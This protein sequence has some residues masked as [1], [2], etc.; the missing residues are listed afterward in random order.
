MNCGSSRLPTAA[1]PATA[2]AAAETLL[3]VL[4]IYCS[5]CACTSAPNVRASIVENDHHLQI[6]PTRLDSTALAAA[7]H[8][9]RLAELWRPNAA[10]AL[11]AHVAPSAAAA[12]FQFDTFRRGARIDS[13]GASLWR[14]YN[15]ARKAS[16]RLRK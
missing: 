10:A 15:V 16:D 13:W 6:S 8:F 2:A 9:C 12:A 4:L 3:I 11:F 14:L 7:A 5:T 1:P